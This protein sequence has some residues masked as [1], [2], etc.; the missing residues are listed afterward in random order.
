MRDRSLPLGI[1]IGSTR[2]RVAHAIATAGG[3]QLRAVVVREIPTGAGLSDA[4][5]DI[6]YTGALI[7]DAV[8]ELER[9]SAGA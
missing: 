4:A 3:P 7:E 8:L 9:V 1:D 2:I 5:C 6:H